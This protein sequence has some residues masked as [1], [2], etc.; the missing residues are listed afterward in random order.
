MRVLIEFASNLQTEFG[1]LVTFIIL[2]LPIHEHDI[3]SPFSRKF[4]S[5]SAEI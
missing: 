4:L 3:F 5:L 2:I 1:H